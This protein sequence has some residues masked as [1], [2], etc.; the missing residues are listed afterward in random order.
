MGNKLAEKLVG[1]QI[2][3]SC[4]NGT[5]LPQE[6]RGIALWSQF[7]RLQVVLGGHTKGIGD[8]VEEG[9]HCDYVNGF[10]NLIVSPTCLPQP[11]HVFA[12]GLAGCFGD[13]FGIVEQS[14][15]G[16]GEIGF[17]EPSFG[18]GAGRLVGCSLNP[19]EV[20]VTV[21]SIGTT[22]ERR[23]VGRQHLFVTPRQMSLGEVE[24]V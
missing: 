11:L 4:R 24:R 13:Q 17:F 12:V 5:N 3:K 22:V 6:A 9:E 2:V 16:G 8:T 15:L 18:D 19:Q 10:R 1:T 21:D 23:N 7:T 14:A 20:G